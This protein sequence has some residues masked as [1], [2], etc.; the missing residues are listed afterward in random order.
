MYL[1]IPRSAA[2]FVNADVNVVLPWS[3]CPIVPTFTCG[4]LRSYFAFAIKYSPPSSV[5]SYFNR[6]AISPAHPVS[7]KTDPFSPGS[8][9]TLNSHTCPTLPQA[10][11]HQSLTCATILKLCRGEDGRSRFA[12]RLTM[13]TARRVSGSFRYRLPAV[14][15]EGLICL[16]H[17]MDVFTF[18]HRCPGIVGRIQQL[19]RELLDHGLAGPGLGIIPQPSERQRNAPNRADLHRHL[20]GRATH[21]PGFYF[22]HRLDIF[23]R[24][25]EDLQRVVI[26][27]SADRFE[28]SVA[29]AL[30]CAL[31]ALPHQG[32]Y[33]LPNQLVVEPRIG[34]GLSRRNTASPGHDWLL[35]Y[36]ARPP[37]DVHARLLGRACLG[38]LR[39]VFRPALSSILHSDGVESATYQMIA[40]SGKIL[41]PA[42]SH[43][44]DRVLLKIVADT[45][46]IRGHFHSIRQTDA[47]DFAQRG[48]RFLRGRRVD[49]DTDASLLRTSGQG[50]ALRLEL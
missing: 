12:I 49:A 42:A 22:D 15:G 32:V 21:A 5:E 26:R 41:H 48:V 46:N 38:A 10:Y 14:M 17:P 13:R 18:F 2:T 34:R 31:L 9:C 29:Y 50:R 8:A 24:R 19:S 30:G 1:P 3:T 11:R 39:P 37:S 33:K 27:A 6:P 47:G 44:H 4:F 20:V 25:T 45:R 23:H 7:A 40:H 16:G 43:K 28:G 36:L 35:P